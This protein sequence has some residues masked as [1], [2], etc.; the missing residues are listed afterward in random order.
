MRPSERA[1]ATAMDP[2]KNALVKYIYKN[3]IRS[4]GQ[5]LEN[6]YKYSKER[7]RGKK[8]CIGI[9]NRIRSQALPNKLLKSLHQRIHTT[10]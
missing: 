10:M 3:G 6:E 5:S 8:V 7:F 2:P 4:G 1:T 9:E